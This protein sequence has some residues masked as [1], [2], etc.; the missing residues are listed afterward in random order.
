VR[1]WKFAA[2]RKFSGSRHYAKPLGR[3]MQGVGDRTDRK[4]ET[5]LNRGVEEKLYLCK[6][7]SDENDTQNN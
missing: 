5:K 2:R 4:I 6:K 3:C 7:V 1:I